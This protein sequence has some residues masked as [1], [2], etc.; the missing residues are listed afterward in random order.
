MSAIKDD[1]AHMIAHIVKLPLPSDAI[2]KFEPTQFERLLAKLGLTEENCDESNV[3]KA[4]CR[5]NR[6]RYFVPEELVKKFDLKVTHDY[7]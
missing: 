2:L 7:E 4:W 6:N 5:T 1:D 3:V